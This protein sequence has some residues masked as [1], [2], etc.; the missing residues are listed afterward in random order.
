MSDQEHVSI[1]DEL[2]NHWGAEPTGR[3][4]CGCG[5]KA[6]VGRHFAP[7]HDSKFAPN[8]LARLRGDSNVTKVVRKL[9]EQGRG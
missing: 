2:K 8:L 5:E 6:K 4:Y 7:G 1:I 9:A 3:C